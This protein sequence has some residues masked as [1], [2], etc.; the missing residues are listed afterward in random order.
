MFV[1]VI[2][3]FVFMSRKVY[4]FTALQCPSQK[5]VN[6]KYNGAVHPRTGLEGPEVE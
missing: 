2:S 1:K 6:G 3:L 5:L 4:W